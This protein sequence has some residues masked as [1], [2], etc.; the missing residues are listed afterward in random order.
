MAWQQ[1]IAE[2]DRCK[3]PGLMREGGHDLIASLPVKQ[4]EAEKRVEKAELYHG[5]RAGSRHLP[6]LHAQGLLDGQWPDG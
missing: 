2:L 4:S 3:E 1:N 6:L 5:K